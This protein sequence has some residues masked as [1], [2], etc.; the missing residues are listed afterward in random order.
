MRPI[1]IGGKPVVC[2][3]HYRKEDCESF[4]RFYSGAHRWLRAGDLA[5]FEAIIAG[6]VK[7]K[8]L[9]VHDD[10]LIEFKVTDRSSRHY[11]PNSEDAAKYTWIH[12]RTALSF[13]GGVAHFSRIPRWFEVTQ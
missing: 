3:A 9:R 10:G 5:Y 13:P 1:V 4:D 6:P 11:P 7:I 8:V 12:P 2:S